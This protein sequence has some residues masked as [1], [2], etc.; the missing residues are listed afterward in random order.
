MESIHPTGY[1]V[2]LK[3]R[4]FVALWIAQILSNTALNGSFFLQ[5]ILIEQVTGSSAQIAAVIV[6]FSLP[7]VLLSALAGMVV[8]RIS[9]KSILVWSNALRVITGAALALVAASLPGNKFAEGYFLTAIYILVFVTSAIGQFFAPAEGSTIPLLVRAENL[10]PANSLFTLTL[11]ASQILGMIILAPLGVKTIGVVGSLWA[12]TIIYALATLSVSLIPYDRPKRNGGIDGVSA[13]RQAWNEIREGWHFAITHRAIFI[14]LLQLALASTLTMVMAEFAPGYAK[15][16]LGLQPEDVTYIFWPAGVGMLLASYLIGRYGHRVPRE[17]LSSI[18]MMGT[19]IGL[20]GMAWAGGG[21][22]LIGKPLF[23]GYPDVILTA[24]AV[25]MLC[26]LIIGSMMATLMIPAQVV[27]Q[28]RSSDVIRGRVFAVQFT[29]SNAIAIPPMLFLGN[30]ADIYGIPYL[31]AAVA[32]L[33]ALLA[34]VNLSWAISTVRAAR[35]RH[36]HHI[37]SSNSNQ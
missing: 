35:L 24:S 34:L 33:V 36:A 4:N 9:K 37:P 13:V 6:A 1:T 15:R 7:A 20:G 3:N 22:V 14:A 12:S 16:V 2:V 30:L 10:L 5:L 21:S 17:I 19:A 11:T 27:V 18:G 28:E 31:I 32:A 8:D 29:L 26:S 25:V 23:V